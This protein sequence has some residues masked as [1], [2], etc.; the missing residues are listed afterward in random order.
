MKLLTVFGFSDA[1]FGGLSDGRSTKSCAIILGC[2]EKKGIEIECFGWLLS[3]SAGRVTRVARSSLAAEVIALSDCIDVIQWARSYLFEVL[4]GRFETHTLNARDQ[5][6]LQTP[7]AR[8]RS[9]DTNA[10]TM[11]TCDFCETT[12]PIDFQ[13]IQET[14]NIWFTKESDGADRMRCLALTDCSNAYASI[15]AVSANSTERSMRIL[16]AYIR[17]NLVSLCLSFV[18][19]SRNIADVGAKLNGNRGIF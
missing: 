12:S 3:A 14:C 13:A 17:D 16:L 8:D 1:G 5:F 19:A 11:V 4:I 6:P 7:F 9:D 2:A 15:N 10:L 18:D